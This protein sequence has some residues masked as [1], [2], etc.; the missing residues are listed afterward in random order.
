MFYAT[1]QALSIYESSARPTAQWCCQHSHFTDEETEVQGG[2]G[3]TAH[4]H[5]RSGGAGL[6]ALVYVS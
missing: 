6:Q 1:F 5:A 3:Q 4:C 2:G